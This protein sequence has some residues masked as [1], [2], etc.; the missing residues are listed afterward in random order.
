[1][2]LALVQLLDTFDIRPHSVT[3]HSSGEIAAAYAAGA[4]SFESCL[5]IAY[6]RGMSA[7]KI[8]EDFPGTQ[9]AMVALG[10]DPNA[11]TDMISALQCTDVDIACFNSPSSVTAS[12]TAKA[13]DQL[14]EAAE[15]RK[16][17]ARKLDVDVA[18]HSAHMKLVAEHYRSA[19]GRIKPSPSKKVLFYSSLTGVKVNT[20][21]LGTTYWVNNLTS[22][23]QFT[24]A[25]QSCCLLKGEQSLSENSVTHVVEIGPHSALKAPIR[26]ILAA[27]PK[28]KYKIDYSSA[29]VR[30]ENGI[31]NIMNLA[32][33]LF[34]RG[35]DV[36]LAAI[37]F[38]R[39]VNTRK[40]L[41]DL[42]PYP[43]N[44]ENRYWHESRIT[45]QQR[46]GSHPRHD[47]LG[48]RIPESSDLEPSWRNVLRLDDV[49]WVGL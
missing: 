2:Q 18:Y 46:L 13:I 33:E 15:T 1:M 36:N 12:G 38:P 9:G 11:T 47:I 20:L 21:A 10:T 34:M 26:D 44:H 48:C 17:F 4:L 29:L 42:P 37:N 6:H 22:P 39:E 40:V 28:K 35:C 3:G 32:S 45:R 24:K 8:S 49:P 31:V 14:K 41:S 30:K 7:Q 5:A 27:A 43:W 16:I 25:F 23:V 19:L